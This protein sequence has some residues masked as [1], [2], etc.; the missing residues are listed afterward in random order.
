[1]KKIISFLIVLV[2]LFALATAP[3]SAKNITTET[4]YFEDGSY[5]VTEIVNEDKSFISRAISTTSGTKTD[6]YYS[7]TGALLFTL[8]VRGTFN[9]NGTVARATASSYS[10][11]INNTS[12]SF[13]GG[14]SSYTANRAT[15]NGTFEKAGAERTL[16]V[17]LYCDQDGNLS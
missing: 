2:S 3:I 5:C 12:W 4:E 14:S 16:S 15:A 17:T 7:A 1:M 8:S 9:Y 11:S 13:V 6:S 10:Y